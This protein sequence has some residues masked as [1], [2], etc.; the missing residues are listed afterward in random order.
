MSSWLCAKET[1]CLGGTYTP[2]LLTSPQKS[3]IMGKKT[4]NQNVPNQ[5]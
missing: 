5:C 3:T 2:R 1:W 4:Q